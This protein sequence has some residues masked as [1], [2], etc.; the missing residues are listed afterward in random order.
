VAGLVFYTVKGL[1]LLISQFNRVS[2]KKEINLPTSSSASNN[3]SAAQT[4]AS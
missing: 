3:G 4:L 1:M 2:P